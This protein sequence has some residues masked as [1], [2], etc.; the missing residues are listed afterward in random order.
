MLLT[1]RNRQKYYMK[2]VGSVIFVIYVSIGT[3][4]HIT[5]IAHSIIEC[6][7][8]CY[9]GLKAT[10]EELMD[11]EERSMKVSYRRLNLLLKCIIFTI[12]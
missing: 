7:Y 12:Y 4:S 2:W 6:R 1:N 11:R 5:F 10:L 8:G 9:L 3:T